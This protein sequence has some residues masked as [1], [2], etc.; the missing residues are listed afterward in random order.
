MPK[1]GQVEDFPEGKVKI[2]RVD[3]ERV[4]ICNVEGTLYAVEDRCTHDDAPLGEGDLEGCEIECPRHGARFDVRDGSV[5]LAPAVY[6]IETYDIEV[7]G[8]EVFVSID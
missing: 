2:V 6:P 1:V 4:A 3:G 8:D 5:T 7:R